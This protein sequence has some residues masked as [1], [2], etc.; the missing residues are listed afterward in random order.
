[1]R[2]SI[3]PRGKGKGFQVIPFPDLPKGDG[4]MVNHNKFIKHPVC[5]VKHSY[6]YAMVSDRQLW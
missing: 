3:F 5:T 6:G 4:V 1:M 2:S